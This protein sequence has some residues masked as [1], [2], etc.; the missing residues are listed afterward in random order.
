M[1]KVGEEVD[2][3][4]VCHNGSKHLHAVEGITATTYE[5]SSSLKIVNIDAPV[6]SFGS[7]SP[8]ATPDI[9]PDLDNGVS[10]ALYDNIWG[11][12]YVMW[13]PFDDKDKDMQY[14]FKLILT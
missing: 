9:E 6:A 2:P 8:F 3:L 12:N 4:T 14:R 5:L 7:S 11:T 10:F 1:S 13:Y